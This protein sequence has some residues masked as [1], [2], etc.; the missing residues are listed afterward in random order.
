MGLAASQAR[1]LG[2]TA[3]KSNVEYQVQQ[4]N[5]QRVALSNEVMG[6]YG[7]Y[8]DLEV[9]T[10]PVVTD[11]MKTTYTID[12][13]L[14]KYQ[15][16][17]FTK[18]TSGEYEGYYD[19]SLTW[20][21]EIAKAYTYSAKDSVITTKKGD[22]GYSY[23]HFQLGLDSYLYDEND[24]ENSTITKITGDYEKYQG[25]NTI[26]KNQGLTDGTFYMFMKNG[27]AYYT[28][29]NDLESTEYET[30]DGKETYY[31]TYT[32]DYQGAQKKT[33]TA[34]A[35]AALT[36]EN[37]GRLSTIQIINSED[38]PELVDKVYSITTSS[39]EDSTLYDE[40][41]NNYEY[42]KMLYEKEVEKLNAKT[43]KLQEEDRAL[44]LQINQLDTEQK[45]LDTEM[46][47]VTKVIEDT[48]DKVFKTFSS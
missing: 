11:Y 15:I 12:S 37:S 31:G 28:S 36:Q 6:L 5:Q 34:T 26:M 40:A 47:S 14:E 42:K 23:L 7:K 9:P 48:I 25:L 3:R 30:V 33:N 45:A 44:E 27:T 32:F 19:V 41:M 8:N 39:V 38:L 16:E 46:E 43:K 21:E 22:D 4:I 13:T 24:L 10:P 2:L 17:N 18:I 35:K 1:F 29:Q 20:D